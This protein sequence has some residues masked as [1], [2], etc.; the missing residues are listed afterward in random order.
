LIYTSA[1]FGTNWTPR[2]ISSTWL[3]VASSADGSN[4]VAAAF[5]PIGNTGGQ[6]YISTN[7]G[8]TWTSRQT[9]GNWWAVASSADGKK[10]IAGLRGGPL[11]L[12][13]N[14]GAIWTATASTDRWVSVA[15]SW[16]GGKLVAAADGLGSGKIYVTPLLASASPSLTLFN[17]ATNTVFVSWPSPS[18]G[19]NLQV[20]GNLATT[21]WVTPAESVTDNGTSKFIIVSPSPGNRFYRLKNP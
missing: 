9:N 11:Y 1:N 15:S 6:L 4:I 5:N 2:G 8:F 10:L 20:N 7:A 14:S 19:Y 18:V 3:S 12:S 13:T 21:N 17:T 16:E